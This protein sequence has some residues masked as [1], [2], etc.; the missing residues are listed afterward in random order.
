MLVNKIYKEIR[1]EKTYNAG[2]YT[3]SNDRPNLVWITYRDLFSL[4]PTG[5]PVGLAETVRF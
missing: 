4:I 2:S 5:K 1:Y 3:H